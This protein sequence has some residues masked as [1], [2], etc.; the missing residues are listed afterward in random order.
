MKAA[1]FILW[2]L[3]WG[4]IILFTLTRPGSTNWCSHSGGK[5]FFIYLPFFVAAICVTKL[6]CLKNIKG[7]IISAFL[8]AFCAL[9]AAFPQSIFWELVFDFACPNGSHWGDRYDAAWV[10]SISSSLYRFFYMESEAVMFF[11]LMLAYVLL[12]VANI[13]RIIALRNKLQANY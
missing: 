12:Y 3:T 5:L 4:P 2:P 7:M 13:F 8:A 11:T 6:E 10:D 1:N 9:L